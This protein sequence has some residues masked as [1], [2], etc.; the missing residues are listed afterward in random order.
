MKMPLFLIKMINSLIFWSKKNREIGTCEAKKK[1]RSTQSS[2]T[3]V[4]LSRSQIFT[5]VNTGH[6]SNHNINNKHTSG[7]YKRIAD[8]KCLLL[9]GSYFKTWYNKK[10]KIRSTQSSS[11]L[12][13]NLEVKYSRRW[14]QATAKKRKQTQPQTWY[15]RVYYLIYCGRD[16]S[17][18]IL[19]MY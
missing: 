1:I 9:P 6:S 19:I 17:F 16:L 11:L 12:L 7:L 13:H 2:S 15:I 8:N 18:K 5:S 4:A 10:E 14:I 3:P